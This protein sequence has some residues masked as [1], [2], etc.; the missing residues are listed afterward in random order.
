MALTQNK[1][2]YWLQLKEDFFASKEMKLL[3]RL[4]GGDEH[5]IIYLKIMLASLQDSGKIYFENLG[6]DLAEEIALLIDEDVE[7]VRMTLLFLTNKKLLTTKDKFEFQLEQVPELIGSETA[8]TRRSRKHREMQKALQ[9]NTDATERNGDIEIEKEIDIN[10]ELEVD[11][12][13]TATDANIYD[14]YQQRIDSLDGFQYEKLKEY[15]E[16]EHFE[17][18][19][20][21][22]AIDKAADGSKRYFN[23]INSILTNWAKNDIRTVARQDEEQRQFVDSKA[24]KQKSNDWVP[25]PNYPPPY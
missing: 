20:V 7:A 17:P 9:C 12:V 19:L 6:N 1:R 16:I 5:T 4:P 13:K 25:D 21:K 3:R 11:T 24:N 2:Y 23:Y 10:I 18:E 22:R 8:S 15:L 14:Y